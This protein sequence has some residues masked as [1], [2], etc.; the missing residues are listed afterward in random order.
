MLWRPSAQVTCCAAALFTEIGLGSPV[1][2]QCYSERCLPDAGQAFECRQ[3]HILPCA[4]AL[5]EMGKDIIA[6]NELC[7]CD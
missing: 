6:A 2:R 1:M 7:R 4:Q 5:F 3:S